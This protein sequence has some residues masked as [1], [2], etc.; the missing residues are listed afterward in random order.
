MLLLFSL[1]S[2]VR[3]YYLIH[4]TFASKSYGLIWCMR[5]LLWRFYHFY[6]TEASG[7][8]GHAGD[9]T[10]GRVGNKFL[11]QGHIPLRHVA[12]FIW[13]YLSNFV[14]KSS[15]AVFVFGFGVGIEIVSLRCLG[16]QKQRWRL[17]LL[18]FFTN[19]DFGWKTYSWLK[20]QNRNLHLIKHKRMSKSHLTGK[21]RNNFRMFPVIMQDGFSMVLV[22]MKYH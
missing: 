19:S 14:N 21:L 6:Q 16:D 22:V 12:Q 7:H 3:F 1:E 10:Q 15:I 4:I 5:E 18:D 20:C 8:F 13:L 17:L 11:S 9:P 2:D